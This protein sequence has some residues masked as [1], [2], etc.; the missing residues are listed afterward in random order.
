MV[1]T[2]WK[3]KEIDKNAAATLSYEMDLP[4]P[5]AAVF[6]ARGIDTPEALADF[7]D[8]NTR[9][10]HSP[11]TLPDIEPVLARL[12]KA[13][14][15]NEKIFCWG[16]YD[17]DGVTA[18]AVVV[19]TLKM[20]GANMEYHTPHR[21]KDGY[22]IKTHSVDRA[23]EL[24]AT[25]LMSVD[26]G[27]LAFETAEYAKKCG[28]DL[29]ITDHHHPHK[30]G[31][32]PD[33]IGV[34]NPNRDDPKYP[35]KK[36]AEFAAPDFQRY[37]F[38]HLAGVGIAFKVMCALWV[39]RG[40]KLGELLPELLEFV[41]L[42]TVAD[43]APMQDENRALVH[44]GCRLLGNSK[45]AGIRELLKVARA[46]KITDTTIGFGLGP[47]INAIGRLGD[48]GIALDLMLESSERRSQ[49]LASILDNTN[50]ERQ[51][52]QERMTQEALELIADKVEDKKIIVVWAK[53]WHKG[54][55]GL[56]ASKVA[57]TYARPTLCLS[58][59]EDGLA[60]GSARSSG[61]FHILNALKSPGC[62]ELFLRCGGH[63]FAAGFTLPAANLELL[64]ERL[65]EYASSYIPERVIHIDA[66]IQPSDIN[67]TVIAHLSK[68]A[69]FGNTNELPKFLCKNLTV[70]GGGTV[71]GGKHLR[72]QLRGPR[73]NS[74]S[75]KAM[76]W[77]KGH[78]LGEYPEGSIVDV[79]FTMAMEEFNGKTTLT[80]TMDDFR[81]SYST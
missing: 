13:L 9:K 78:L 39:R 32:I 36:F 67:S 55:V 80:M 72:L 38:D 79:V 3:V 48:S 59:I 44:L 73:E 43:V 10:L 57:E 15:D 5:V 30:D 42:G 16:D 69:P 29:I 45:K 68:L 76:A 35:G 70:I 7:C 23:V 1:D 71:T 20:L 46:T 60:Q 65:N 64:D 8:L 54:V 52:L 31:T 61:D 77:R 25:L 33:C 74:P 58:L 27:I 19:T 28:I 37:P 41:A 34:V 53:G 81:H 11:F 22:D 4:L 26:C 75:L 6:A 14:D 51:D 50:K 66:R 47:R 17:V 56:V 18:T 62:D 21:M 49:H 24:G 12:G 63:S 2:V 40:R